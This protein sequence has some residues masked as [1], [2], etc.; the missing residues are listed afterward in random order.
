M[1]NNKKATIENL[2]NQAASAGAMA[3]YK[4]MCNYPHTDY[5]KSLEALLRAY[6]K[7]R[8]WVDHPEEYG[9]FPTEKSKSIT[10]APPAGSMFI[11]TVD[12]TE[13]Y[14]EA[15][16]RSFTRSLERFFDLWI[17]IDAFKNRREFVVI[18]M[19]YFG[20]DEYG[21]YRGDDAKRYTWEEIAEALSCAG[22]EYSESALREWRNNIMREMV[23]M[24]WGKDGAMSINTKRINP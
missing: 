16:K 23:V 19:Y 6:P 1:M 2:I 7:M 9:F 8:R 22:H 20:E 10:V 5:Y 13:T 21:N 11:D 24:M 14:L 15:R 3:A 4:A 17:V 12:L 18:R